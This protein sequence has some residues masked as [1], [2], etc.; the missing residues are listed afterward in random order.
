[1]KVV[2]IIIILVGL[3]NLA[4]QNVKSN[5]FIE[6]SDSLIIDSNSVYLPINI[7]TLEHLEYLLITKNEDES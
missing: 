7:I 1:M 6:Y 2:F 5:D 4:G 3:L